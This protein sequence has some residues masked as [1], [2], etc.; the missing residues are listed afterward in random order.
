M[1]FTP[2]MPT[3]IPYASDDF[4]AQSTPAAQHTE[5]FT[6]TIYL[7]S[8]N[9]DREGLNGITKKSFSSRHNTIFT[10]HEPEQ[11]PVK[12]RK[13]PQPMLSCVVACGASHGKIRVRQVIPVGWTCAA[14]YE[15]K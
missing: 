12:T 3:G 7:S 5:P 8:I 9:I 11:L 14:F 10:R 1:L 6:V 2:Y 15:L 13:A 4:S